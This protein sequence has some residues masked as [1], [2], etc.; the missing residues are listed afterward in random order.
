MIKAD[1]V[2]DVKGL[3]CP[4]PLLMT[5]QAL[6]AMQPGQILYI[7]SDDPTTR[8]TFR[9]F[10]DGSGDELLDVQQDGDIIH[11]YVRKK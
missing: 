4:R 6:K 11:H 2:L 10:I 1:Q 5:K 8:L 7:T 9:S 3:L